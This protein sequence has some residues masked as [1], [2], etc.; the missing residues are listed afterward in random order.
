MKKKHK[1]LTISICGGN[2]NKLYSDLAGYLD[3]GWKIDRVDSPFVSTHGPTSNIS[4]IQVFS[5]LVYIL[6]KEE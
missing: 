1:I 4:E 2:A 6:S 3:S 5:W